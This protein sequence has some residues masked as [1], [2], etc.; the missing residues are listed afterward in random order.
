VTR[1]LPSNVEVL[2]KAE[3]LNP[4]GSIKDRAA[5]AMIL[6][7]ERSGELTAGKTILDATS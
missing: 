5:L 3:H 7:G 4:G 1:H 2:V 6:A